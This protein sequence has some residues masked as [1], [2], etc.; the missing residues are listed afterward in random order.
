MNQELA[1]EWVRLNPKFVSDDDGF[2]ATL[3]HAASETLHGFFAPLLILK[4]L[5][6]YAF[7]LV[8][9]S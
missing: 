6:G 3:S 2:W 8:R 1:K 4:W 9:S 7:R 5:V